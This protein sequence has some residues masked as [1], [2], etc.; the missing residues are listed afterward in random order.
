MM[1]FKKSLIRIPFATIA[2][3][4]EQQGSCC[5]LDVAI[6][7]PKQN[8]IYKISYLAVIPGLPKIK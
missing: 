6:L 3:I 1:P 5:P 4:K 8:R 7:P 2:I